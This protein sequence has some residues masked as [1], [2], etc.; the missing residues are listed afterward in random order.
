MSDVPFLSLRDVNAR[1]RAELVAAFEETLDA[2]WFIKGE[3]CAAFERE[4]AAFCGAGSCLGVANG[5]DALRLILRA[6]KE[7]RGWDDFDEVVL[8]ANTFIATILAVTDNR[9]KPVLVEPDLSTFLIDPEAARAAVGPR[10]RAILPVHLYGQV[11]DMEPLARLGRERGLVVIEDSAQAHGALYRGRRAGSLGDA[12][13]FSFYPGKN[14]GALGDG[15]AIVTSDPKLD[16]CARMMANNGSVEKYVHEIKGVNSRLDELQAA[17]L[18]VKLRTL[19][20]DN[21][22]RRAISRR[23]REGIRS[24]LVALPRCDDEERH[25][26]HIFAIRSPE[27]EA[28]KAHLQERGIHTMIHYPIPPHL[29]GAYRELSSSSL[30]VTERIHREEL[31]LPMSPTMDDAEVEMVIEAINSY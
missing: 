27:R 20:A 8:P 19:D 15:G 11:A 10:T 25:V 23:Y 18:S 26:W 2:G 29:Q 1:H 4:F 31:S 13:G 22:R 3:R 28:L 5:L 12:A 16:S 21:E 17:F 6:Y 14:L 9:L 7:T 30:P 24:P